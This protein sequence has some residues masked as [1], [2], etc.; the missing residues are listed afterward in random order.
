ML[1]AGKRHK[2]ETGESLWV[3][4][5]DIVPIPEHLR[6]HL[7]SDAISE[8][9]VETARSMFDFNAEDV[10]GNIAPRPLMLLHAAEDSV[11]P[12]EQSL[13]MFDR[14]GQPTDLILLSDVDHWPL[15][16]EKPRAE[17]MMKDW[18]DVYLPVGG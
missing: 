18:L 13:R 1:E 12:T 14:A 8:F 10:V 2:E 7:V 11:T 3:S 17:A 9:P 6:K 4:R 16:G 15:A 5:W